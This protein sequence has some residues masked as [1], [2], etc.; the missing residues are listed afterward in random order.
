MAEAVLSWVGELDKAGALGVGFGGG[1]PTAHP[2][3]ARI[4]VEAARS[5]SMAV[6]FTTHGHRIDEELAS[7]VR[8]SVHF[9][10]LSM[11]GL[12][13]TYERLRGRSFEAFQR[14]IEIVSSIAPFGLNVV[15]N[16]DTIGE[17][18]P[19]ARFA[20]EVGAAEV[21]LLPEQGVGGRSGI[22]R[23]ASQVLTEWVLSA[24]PGVRL[25]ISEAGVTGGMPLANP[26]PGELPLDAHVHVDARGVLKANA[27]AIDGISV[28]T[29][30]LETLDQLRARRTI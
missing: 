5:T 15:I 7:V 30:I 24:S 21:L 6:T 10:R 18:E 19:I 1:E 14:Q 9:V 2:E 16:D 26:F 25:A 17:L 8:G 23:S 3:F 20:R 11:D 29:S 12:G 4:C 13:A 22:S 28:G 27:Y